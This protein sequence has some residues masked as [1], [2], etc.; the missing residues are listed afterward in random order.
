M[1]GNIE[2]LPFQS[3]NFNFKYLR[4]IIY[5]LMYFKSYI[6]YNHELL[7][8]NSML[9]YQNTLKKSVDFQKHL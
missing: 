5:I 4:I 1:N 8:L 9:K 7:V 2:D 3:T 6:S